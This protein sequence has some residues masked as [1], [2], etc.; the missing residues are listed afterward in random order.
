MEV[1]GAGSWLPSAGLFGVLSANYSV[2]A[3]PLSRGVAL[4]DQGLLNIGVVA[5]APP[6]AVVANCYNATIAQA[7]KL[8]RT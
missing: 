2:N 1:R 5:G 3:A 8:L 4:G 6:E 7:A